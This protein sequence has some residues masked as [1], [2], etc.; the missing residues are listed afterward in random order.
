MHRHIGGAGRS[1]R[2]LARAGLG[3]VLLGAGD[4][5]AAPAEV[6]GVEPLRL[7]AAVPDRLMA[8]FGLAEVQ[9]SGPGLAVL[10][11]PPAAT[12]ERAAVPTRPSGLPWPSGASCG[13]P[14]FA[15]WRGRR[16]DAQVQ[17]VWHDTWDQMAARLN[18]PYYRSQ[19]GLTPQPVISLAL[20]PKSDAYQ[21][22]RCAKG[23]FDGHFR[24]FGQIMAAIGAGRAIVRV[25][26][27]PNVGAIHHPWAFDTKDQVPAYLGCFR[28]AVTALRAGASTLRIEWTV[29]KATVWPFS[30]LDAYP[31][32]GYVDVMGTHY[33]DV[34]DQFST[35][36]KWDN[37]Y[38]DRVHGGPQGL[39]PWIETVNAR[40]KQLGIGE[41][42]VWARFVEPPVA[43]SPV[44]V[45]NM[46]QFF[47]KNAPSI[48][49]E[50]YY[51]CGGD[52]RLYPDGPFPKASATYQK[53]WSG[54]VQ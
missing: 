18:S 43:D 46:Y 19:V 6:D 51:N 38:D 29:A 24:Q 26:W 49:Y 8:G 35:Q 52:H 27:E 12:V 47:R 53:L 33:Y 5:R 23:E 36:R 17:F 28:H 1:L 13:L 37:F 32:D 20:L 42:G 14:E 2:S 10:A 34:A 48:A 30:V 31:G 45:R 50:S 3:A 9:P 15:A 22:A 7:P 44:Y 16:L 4:A 39:G 41:W 21:F 11:L 54:P 40:G 25:G